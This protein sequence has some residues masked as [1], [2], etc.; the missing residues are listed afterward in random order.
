[1]SSEIMAVTLATHLCGLDHSMLTIVYTQPSVPWEFTLENGKTNF[2]SFL[3][4]CS[5]GTW[6]KILQKIKIFYTSEYVDCFSFFVCWEGFFCVYPSGVPISQNSLDLSQS[7][8]TQP[9]SMPL[10][11]GF[12]SDLFGAF[13]A[14]K[15]PLQTL[16]YRTFK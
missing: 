15:F 14:C 8:S 10:L 12:G 16:S 11:T 1:M 2:K 9:T 6:N 4:V 13:V 5:V 7:V 3:V